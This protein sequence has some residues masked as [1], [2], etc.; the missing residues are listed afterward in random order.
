MATYK[1]KGA[2][3]HLIDLVKTIIENRS[4]GSKKKQQK[5]IKS[6]ESH[7]ENIE[8]KFDDTLSE[9][10]DEESKLKKVNQWV[11]VANAA[12]DIA[13][14][15]KGTEAAERE[16]LDIEKKI[17][18]EIEEIETSEGLLEDILSSVQ[19]EE[20]QEVQR[21]RTLVSE[22][23]NLLQEFETEL[24]DM[25]QGVIEEERLEKVLMDLEDELQH[26]DMV[27]TEM[28]ETTR[29]LVETAKAEKELEKTLEKAEQEFQLAKQDEEELEE[30]IKKEEAKAEGT[31]QEID[32]ELNKEETMSKSLHSHLAAEG[33]ELHQAEENLSSEK[34]ELK[35]E[36]VELNQESE[37]L[38]AVLSELL[39][40]TSKTETFIQNRNFKGAV[41]S[42]LDAVE[43]QIKSLE[44]NIESISAKTSN[45]SI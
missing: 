24:R 27:S 25:Q 37:E 11:D 30:V 13:K 3:G 32:Q 26:I 43:S 15:I 12:G 2:V 18:T 45:V 4:D 8:K 9:T 5:R 21:I 17:G 40:L 14:T 28:K 6:L 22:T 34:R 7:I 20:K 1:K 38:E 44:K 33:Q 41:S 16:M 42:R 29:E 31:N 39:E 19:G 35:A 36:L 23:R 10:K